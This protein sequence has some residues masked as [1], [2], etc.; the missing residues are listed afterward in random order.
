MA[1]K[2]CDPPP[3]TRAHFPEVTGS[4]LQEI[5]Q[6]AVPVATQRTTKPWL[7]LF[8]AYLTGKHIS[9]ELKKCTPEELCDV[10]RHFYVEARRQNGQTYQRTSLLGVRAAIQRRLHLPE[11]RRLDL[12]IIRGKE[13]IL[14]NKALDS[15]LKH[16]ATEGLLQPA[17]HKQPLSNEDLQKCMTYFCEKA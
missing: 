2:E 12:G 11:I 16:L 6:T 7:A 17:A 13:F 3:E 14:A 8:S 4:F 9:L 5:E 15:Y 1:G 10:L